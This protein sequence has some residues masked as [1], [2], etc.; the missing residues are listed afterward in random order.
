MGSGVMS[1]RLSLS[2]FRPFSWVT[3]KTAIDI[4]IAQQES[5]GVHDV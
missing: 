5:E 3:D 1:V 4:F 2:S